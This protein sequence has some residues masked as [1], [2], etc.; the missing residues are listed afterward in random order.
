[1]NKFALSIGTLTLGLVI[2]LGI[3][4]V[5]AADKDEGWQFWINK[6]EGMVDMSVSIVR[7]NEATGETWVK[8]GNRYTRIRPPVN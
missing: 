1:M 7:Y 4:S 5:N 3:G 6:G 8:E 2:G